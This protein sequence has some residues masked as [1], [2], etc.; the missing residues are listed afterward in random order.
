MKMS[1]I[2]LFLI[3]ASLFGVLTIASADDLKFGNATKYNLSFSTN[4]VCSLALGDIEKYTIKIINQVS[5]EETCKYNPNQ[6]VI[7]VY[8]E[9]GCAGKAV[10][11]MIFDKTNIISIATGGDIMIRGNGS[12][13]FF[14]TL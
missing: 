2:A 1:K 4:G 10:A 14:N 12:N 3:T 8:K 9:L 11:N 6:C 5:F 7:D 13:V